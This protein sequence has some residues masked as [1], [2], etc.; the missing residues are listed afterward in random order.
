MVA[1]YRNISY[2]IGAL[3]EYYAIVIDD[4]GADIFIL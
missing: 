3:E 2:Q 1:K 4:S